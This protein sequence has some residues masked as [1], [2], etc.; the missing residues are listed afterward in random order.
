MGWVGQWS[1]PGAHFRLKRLRVGVVNCGG[2]GSAM[3]MLLA[4]LGAGP[5]TVQDQ[6][7]QNNPKPE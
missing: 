1:R 7:S 6:E 3:A 4:H 2:T 5:M